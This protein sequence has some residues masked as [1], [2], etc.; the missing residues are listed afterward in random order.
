MAASLS[1]GTYEVL[2]RGSTYFNYYVSAYYPVISNA[3]S[4]TI[5]TKTVSGVQILSGQTKTQN[6]SY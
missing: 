6:F 1:D 4:V 3:G 5:S 2:A